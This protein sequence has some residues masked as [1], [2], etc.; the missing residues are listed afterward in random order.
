MSPL[1][2][3]ISLQWEGRDAYNFSISDCE[4]SLHADRNLLIISSLLLISPASDSFFSFYGKPC[5]YYDIGIMA[6]GRPFHR[7]TIIFFLVLPDQPRDMA[8][9]SIVL[10]SY[11]MVTKVPGY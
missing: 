9:G 8:R 7:K 3:I 11:C 4:V 10:N 1:L 2:K 5:I 6:L